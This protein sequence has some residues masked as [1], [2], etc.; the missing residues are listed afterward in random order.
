MKFFFTLHI[1][2]L[3]GTETN[4]SEQKGISFEKYEYDTEDSYNDSWGANWIDYNN[5]G[6]E[7]LFIPSYDKSQK[8]T[9]F[10][11]NKGKGFIKITD[12]QPVMDNSNATASSWADFD[13]NGLPDLLVAENLVCGNLV[14]RNEYDGDFKKEKNIALTEIGYSSHGATWADVNLDGYIDA[15]VSD[16]SVDKPSRLF[17]NQEGESFESIDFPILPSSN[18]NIGASWADVNN[19]SYPDLFAPND[20]GS[21][22]LYI[23]NQD[24]TFTPIVFEGNGSSVGCSFGDIDNDGDLDLFVT[25][26]SKENNS[27]FINDGTGSFSLDQ[28][29]ILSNDG[30]DSHGSCFGDFNNDGWLD[31][32][33]TNDR[34][35]KKYFYLNQGDGSFIRKTDVA[36]V[37]KS[38]NAFGVAAADFDKDGDLDI[39]IANHNNEK[40]EMYQNNLTNSNWINIQLRGNI[41]NQSAI[42]AKIRIKTV[43]NNESKWLLR[44]I[45]AQSGGGSGS[46]NSLIAHF[47]LGINTHIDSMVIE[48]PSKITQVFSEM[49]ANKN[50]QID[51][52]ES[53]LEEEN[54]LMENI[55]SDYKKPFNV[56]NDFDLSVYPNPTNG[57]SEF[58]VAKKTFVNSPEDEAALYNS[59]GE[60]ILSWKNLDLTNPNELNISSYPKGV[61]ILHA[62]INGKIVTKKI[63]KM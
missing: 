49:P 28:N 56:N 53:T 5:D 63:L 59:A 19:D 52:E 30:G 57:Y 35:G 2:V 51:E 13:N 44:E 7:D 22:I 9:L 23:N 14:Y 29:S 27:L 36:I 40:N 46:Q 17:I 42:G 12:V 60:L 33:V 18:R 39:F 58:K 34:G 32:I 55:A 45:S 1:I 48:W 31:L 38:S 10:Q 61:Y 3:F 20:G 24:L 47:G 41:S 62:K 4:V 54:T 6:W 25:N 15:F 26:A 37:E 21:N 8:N 11:N 43:L 50:Y 16:F